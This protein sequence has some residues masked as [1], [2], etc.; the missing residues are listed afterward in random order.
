MASSR[1][2]LDAKREAL[3]DAVHPIAQAYALVAVVIEKPAAQ[4]QAPHA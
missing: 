1:E 3:R 2:H 4:H